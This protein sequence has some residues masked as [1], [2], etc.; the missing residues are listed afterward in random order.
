M[1]TVNCMLGNA[2]YCILYL[3][4]ALQIVTI[5]C[6]WRSGYINQVLVSKPQNLS[7]PTLPWA[8]YHSQ[9]L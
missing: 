8:V 9:F 1:Y 7:P 6:D 3:N 5:S 4:M 2:S